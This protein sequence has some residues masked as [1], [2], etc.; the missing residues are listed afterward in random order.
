MWSNSEIDAILI[1]VRW[2]ITTW[3]RTQLL[4]WSKQ[5]GLFHSPES[6]R[7]TVRRV[8]NFTEWNEWVINFIPWES[9]SITFVRSL[10]WCSCNMFE[11]YH[12]TECKVTKNTFVKRGSFWN[13]V[14][15]G[16]S[17]KAHCTYT[18]MGILRG[19]TSWNR[20]VFVHLDICEWTCS[21][22]VTHLRCFSG[23][24]VPAD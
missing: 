1:S 24:V 8:I 19:K 6:M 18:R 2:I 11:L 22:S 7:I 4:T 9:W 5:K 17:L 23:P 14:K 21:A 13:Q 10:L 3:P 15:H 16:W 12:V 20:H